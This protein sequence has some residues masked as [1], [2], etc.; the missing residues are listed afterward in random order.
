MKLT[1]IAEVK[2]L[3]DHR[4]LRHSNCSHKACMHVLLI[5]PIFF[6]TSSH[7]LPYFAFAEFQ[8]FFGIIVRCLVFIFFCECAL[9]ASLNRVIVN[10]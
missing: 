6:T 5:G 7:N 2:H 10:S 1:K 4:Y 9:L 8:F 3:A